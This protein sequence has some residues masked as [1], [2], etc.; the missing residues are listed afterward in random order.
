MAKRASSKPA[1]SLRSDES[2]NGSGPDGDRS[3]LTSDQL[4]DMK[5]LFAELDIASTAGAEPPPGVG[6][7]RFAEQT[8]GLFDRRLQE[9]A[10]SRS[11]PRDQDP[12]RFYLRRI[13]SVSLLSRD[14]E[15][16]LAR[17]I[18]RGELEARL[19]CGRAWETI[20]PLLRMGAHDGGRR[21]D[22]DHE[23][24]EDD[25]IE[26][27]EENFVALRALGKLRDEWCRR[28]ASDNGKKAAARRV[29]EEQ[30]EDNLEM[31]YEV[32]RELG[33]STSQFR[34]ICDRVHDLAEEARG[35]IKRVERAAA[36]AGMDLRSLFA[37]L[38]EIRKNGDN[39]KANR[40]VADDVRALERVTTGVARRLDTIAGE[41]GLSVEALIQVDD[42]LRCA[43][44][45]ADEARSA[46]VQANLRLVVSI[47]KKYVNRGL[48][49]LDLIQ[50]GNIGLMRA[51]EKFEYRRGYKFSTYA[52]WWIRQAITRAIADQ[53]RTIR[54]PVHMTE[55][56][57]QLRRASV[58]LVQKL[59]R[60]PSLEEI[61][62]ELEQPVEKVLMWVRASKQPISLETPIGSEDDFHLMDIIEDR[63]AIRQPDAVDAHEL[64]RKTYQALATLTPRE[65]RVLRLRFGIGEEASAT[66]EEVGHE[67]EVT[68]ERIR[69]IEAKALGKLREPCRSDRLAHFWK[70]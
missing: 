55:N 48:P 21:G 16:A 11:A 58:R 5:I 62:S 57:H 20:V 37:L 35:E 19:A 31:V 2:G 38:Q 33:L 54:V 32:D 22:L 9:A 61:A 8:E 49:L 30:L 39:D 70:G 13:A 59:G 24:L 67:F 51:V 14:G 15:V 43:R 34:R 42:N 26:Q 6:K 29:L 47:A 4:G 41:S 44:V 65:E 36:N 3:R 28:A 25:E 1:V 10:D 40:R 60:E 46:L 23:R 69:Q 7:E 52:H 66:L 27:L 18:E 53:S 64:A 68:R 50:E 12:V 45:D 56:I 63:E 17:R